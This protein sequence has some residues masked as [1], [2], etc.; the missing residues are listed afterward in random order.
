MSPHLDQVRNGGGTA[1]MT[2]KMPRRKSVCV[3]AI[4][5][6]AHKQY[7]GFFV[8]IFMTQMLNSIMFR[9]LY[10]ISPKSDNKCGK[11]IHKF[12]DTPK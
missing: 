10:P 6:Y 8:L 5:V 9:S 4:F 2:G 3:Y 12:I 11:Y 1:Q 7:F